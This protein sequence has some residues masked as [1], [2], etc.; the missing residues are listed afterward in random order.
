LASYVK[1]AG[2]SRLVIDPVGP[3]INSLN[4]ASRTREH[5]RMLV[6]F[7]QTND[8]ETTNLMT[9][10]A[11]TSNG[12][13]GEEDFSLS[14]IVVLKLCQRENGLTRTLLIRKMQGTAFDLVEHEFHITRGRGIVLRPASQL[15]VIIPESRDSSF[16]EWP[17]ETH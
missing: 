10:H 7:L 11:P 5:F 17:F 15:A 3:L 4:S 6:R 2:A 16:R 13:G 1:R 12:I 14:G 8:M 9:A